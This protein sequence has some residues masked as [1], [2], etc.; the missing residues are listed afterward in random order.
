MHNRRISRLLTNFES[1][2]QLSEER[3]L[4]NSEIHDSLVKDKIGRYYLIHDILYRCDKALGGKLESSPTKQYK[5][6]VKN[7]LDSFENSVRQEA[8]RRKLNPIT[9]RRSTINSSIDEV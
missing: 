1:A 4:K 8:A 5:Q 7:T 2:N 6:H 3:A 9:M